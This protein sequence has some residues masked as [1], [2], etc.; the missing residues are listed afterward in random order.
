MKTRSSKR[1]KIDILPKGL[2]NDFGPKFL[3][4]FYLVLFK[5]DLQEMFRHTFSRK[6]AFLFYKSNDF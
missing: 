2:T 5:T 4:Q 6:K 1:R 3:F